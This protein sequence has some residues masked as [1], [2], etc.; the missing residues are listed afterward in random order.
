MKFTPKETVRVRCNG[1]EFEAIYS[2]PGWEVGPDDRV[3]VYV[4]RWRESYLAKEV[5]PQSQ[6]ILHFI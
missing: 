3:W 6:C 4:G 2:G 1:Q 5:T